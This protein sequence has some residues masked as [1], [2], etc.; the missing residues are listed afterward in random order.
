[1]M[2]LKVIFS[3]GFMLST[4]VPTSYAGSQSHNE[5]EEQERGPKGGKLFR[6]GNFSV[7]LT[8]YEQGVPPQISCICI[9][10]TTN[11]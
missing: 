2:V 7:E 5:A 11:N 10:K 1:M 3:V 9:R 6:D 8:I 4:V